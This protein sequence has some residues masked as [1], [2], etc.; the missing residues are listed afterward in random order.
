MVLL[1]KR[2]VVLYAAAAYRGAIEERESFRLPSILFL[3]PLPPDCKQNGRQ[4]EGE[5][6]KKPSKPTIVPLGR[7]GLF[8]FGKWHR[9]QMVANSDQFQL[10]SR[11]AGFYS[12][13]KLKLR[14]SPPKYVQLV[15]INQVKWLGPFCF[16]HK[17]V[18]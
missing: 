7:K 10:I 15:D 11:I 17:I 9:S 14:N 8:C 5:D 18:K 12:S 3:A 4:A 2:V 1:Q 6:S 13:K 16:L